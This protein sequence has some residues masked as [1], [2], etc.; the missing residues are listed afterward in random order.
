MTKFQVGDQVKIDNVKKFSGPGF[1]G[2]TGIVTEVREQDPAPFVVEMTMKNGNKGA[3]C[4]HETELAK[5]K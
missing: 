2:C 5:I 1:V 4:F 3:A